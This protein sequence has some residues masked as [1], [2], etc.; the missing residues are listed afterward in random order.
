MEDFEIQ[1]S[2]MIVVVLFTPRVMLVAYLVSLFLE[3]Y[4]IAFFL[5]I[6]IAIA[7]S[8]FY[9]IYSTHNRCFS[10][11]RLDRFRSSNLNKWRLNVLYLLI[12]DVILITLFMCL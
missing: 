5:I 12:I 2:A 6:E 7:L 3:Y 10:I 11:K 1:G 8:V 4:F 9:S